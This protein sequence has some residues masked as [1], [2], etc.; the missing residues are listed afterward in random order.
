MAG[1]LL[2]GDR[3]TLPSCTRI[4]DVPQDSACSTS[5]GSPAYSPDGRL[6][7]VDAGTQLAILD[8]DGSDFRL[9]LHTADDGEPVW[10]PDG[11]RIAFTGTRSGQ[12][13]SDLYVLDVARGTSR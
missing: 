5:V 8:S 12:T 9:L 13:S 1:P 11:K 3:Y 6:L 2:G 4:D 7:V 10:A